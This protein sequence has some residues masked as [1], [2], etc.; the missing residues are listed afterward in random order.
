MRVSPFSLLTFVRCLLV[1]GRQTVS[2]LCSFRSLRLQLSV[3]SLQLFFVSSSGSAGTLS[4]PSYR[5]EPVLDGGGGLATSEQY[6]IQGSLG[7]SQL[8]FSFLALAVTGI[9]A[10][11]KQY[12][13]TT[14]A[15]LDLHNAA[16]QGLLDEDE[17]VLLTH[18]VSGSFSDKEIG[19][20]KTVTVSGLD[21]GGV[22]A[23]YYYLIEPAL[24]ADIVEATRFVSLPAPIQAVPYSRSL[25][26]AVEVTGHGELQL[27]WL[28][29]GNAIAGAIAPTLTIANAQ[30]ADEGRYV[31]RVSTVGPPVLSEGI[32]V[33]VI[34]LALDDT[35]ERPSG[36][37][38]KVSE[39]VLLENDL[40]SD[41]GAVVIVSVASETSVGGEVFAQDG[42]VFYLPPED[43]NNFDSF[44]YTVR[45]GRGKTATAVVGVEVRPQDDGPKRNQLRI[46]RVEATDHVHLMFVGTPGQAYRIEATG[47][48]EDPDWVT[49]ATQ[50]AGPN[51]LY[52]YID[53]E[54]D[55]FDARF[56]RAV[57]E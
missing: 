18:A 32:N 14:A 54:A 12:D 47:E 52:E 26:L 40:G 57:K 30:P 10:L 15:T 42:W 31:L 13:G 37:A 19:A 44:T 53:S 23:G 33:E 46:G 21:L 4:S 8:D 17:V 56:Y 20:D 1:K 28:K 27:Q 5:I 2:P 36:G 39:K 11:D 55:N 24:T 29:D 3:F 45:D 16:L 22:D 50:V 6:S 25:Q 43:F 34:P 7:L 51:G 9:T 38:T 35:V 49:L 41:G 48:I